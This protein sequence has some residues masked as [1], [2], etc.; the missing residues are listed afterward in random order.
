[1]RLLTEFALWAGR[2]PVSLR[3]KAMRPR[4]GLWS[5]E[6]GRSLATLDALPDG[7]EAACRLD[8]KMAGDRADGSLT[9]CAQCSSEGDREEHI[10]AQMFGC[11][12]QLGGWLPHT[13]GPRL[14]SRLEACNAS[15]LVSGQSLDMEK[16]GPKC[17][18]PEE[19]GVLAE[20]GANGF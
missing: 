2:Y 13:R 1:M 3:A 12:V 18:G 17:S 15:V 8:Q 20:E 9:A 7:D 19:W 14:A 6:V 11:R 10:S 4:P 16:H 5:P